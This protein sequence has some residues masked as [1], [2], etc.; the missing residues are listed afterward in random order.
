MPFVFNGLKIATTLALIGAIVAEYF[1]SPTRGMGFRIRPG[2]AR[3]HR[4]RLGGDRGGRAHRIGGLWAGGACR[5]A[6][7]AS[8]VDGAGGRAA[9]PAACSSPE[10]QG[11]ERGPQERGGFQGDRRPSRAGGIVAPVPR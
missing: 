5:A 4:S 8:G 11:Q 6:G 10:A 7:D 1:G 3:S 9:R 2:W